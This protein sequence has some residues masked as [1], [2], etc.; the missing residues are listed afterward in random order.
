M[1]L[2][3]DIQGLQSD[4]VICIFHLLYKGESRGPMALH[5]AP[6]QSTLQNEA[7]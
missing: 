3:L 7:F 4:N 1:L 2:Y 6:N 5:L